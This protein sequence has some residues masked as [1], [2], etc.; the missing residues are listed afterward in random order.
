MVVTRYVHRYMR[1]RA[2][3]SSALIAARRTAIVALW[4][5]ASALVGCQHKTT[6]ELNLATL[7]IARDAARFAVAASTDS[8]VTF[9]P[10]EVRWL[11]PGMRGHV[12]D[13][14]QRDALI[15]RLTIQRVDTGGTIATIAGGVSPVQ[16]THV[17]LFEKPPTSWW[18]D[19]R[20][21]LGS[22]A[23]IVAGV[24]ATSASK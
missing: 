13:P 16:L 20:F 24:I 18:R 14:S 22:G 9:R 15:A 3:R 17:V 11:R 2:Q 6:P 8:S 19:R 12:V 10:A 21:W 23:G 7:S 5:G 4:L 1:H